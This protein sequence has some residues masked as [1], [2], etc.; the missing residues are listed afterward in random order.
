[1]RLGASPFSWNQPHVHELEDHALGHSDDIG[2]S[3][4][5]AAKAVLVEVVIL[6]VLAEI[7]LEGSRVQLA[8]GTFNI[9]VKFGQVAQSRGNR[10][11]KLICIKIPYYMYISPK[12]FHGREDAKPRQ[13]FLHC[14]PHPDLQLEEIVSVSVSILVDDL[15]ALGEVGNLAVTEDAHA[16]RGII[17]AP[18]VDKGVGRGKADTGKVEGVLQVSW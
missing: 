4:A 8:G 12:Y 1:V 5:D 14:F 6:L 13:R 15:E 16:A 18:L 7:W 11:E 2:I 9:V 3:F 10:K 17:R